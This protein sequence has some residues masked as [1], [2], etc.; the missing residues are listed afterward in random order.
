MHWVNA[1][2]LHPNFK[3]SFSARKGLGLSQVKETETGQRESGRDQTHVFF[4]LLLN[5]LKI[6][7]VFAQ[8]F[9]QH[10]KLANHYLKIKIVL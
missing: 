9:R 3:T 5:T 1:F 8:Q 6:V 7:K 10:N 4:F 2:Q